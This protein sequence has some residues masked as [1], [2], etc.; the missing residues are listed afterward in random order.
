MGQLSNIKI[1]TPTYKEVVP[2]T[3]KAIKLKPFRVGDEKALLMASQSQDSKQMINTLKEVISNCSEGVNVNELAPFDLEYLFLKLRAVSV[4]EITEIGLKCTHCETTNK[5][6]L[7]LAKVKIKEEEG[8]TNFVKINQDL[9]FEMRYPD[10]TE[11]ADISTEEMDGIIDVVVKSVKNVFHGED[12]IEVGPADYDDLKNI[13]NSLT[14]T[15]FEMI[16]KFFTTSPKLSHDI[17]FKCGH[18]SGDNKQTLEGLSS[19]F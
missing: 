2:S 4:G 13:L 18:C 16:Q 1:A 5:I 14:T 3:K 17:V 11:V 7:D 6:S 19:F 15:Q 9:I 10:L 8:H 12:T